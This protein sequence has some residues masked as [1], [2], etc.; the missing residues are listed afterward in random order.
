MKPQLDHLWSWKTTHSPMVKPTHGSLGRLWVF[1]WLLNHFGLILTAN[2]R[3]I[4]STTKTKQWFQ[5]ETITSDGNKDMLKYYETIYNLISTY[6]NQL[7]NSQ[8]VLNWWSWKM[9]IIDYH[10]NLRFNKKVM[11]FFR[12]LW[13][14]R[15]G[16]NSLEYHH[17]ASCGDHKNP[18]HP[19]NPG[20]SSASSGH[21][22]LVPKKIA[23][24]GSPAARP[25]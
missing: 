7:L 11:S 24:P 20:H 22:S 15:W 12:I 4:Q 21:G 19:M 23:A 10:F 14:Q 16:L 5:L 1:R 3:L 17:K 18:G 6:I 8:H 25:C 13:K 2:K 9:M